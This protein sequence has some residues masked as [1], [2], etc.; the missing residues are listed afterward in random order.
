[1]LAEAEEAEREAEDL[2]AGSRAA[3]A[4]G[5][6][7]ESEALAQEAASLRMQ[8]MAVEQQAQESRLLASIRETE[9]KVKPLESLP[10]LLSV[11]LYHW[12]LEK[13]RC[14]KCPGRV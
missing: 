8:S 10:P 14:E 11:M 1:M 3:A 2:E 7:D 13:R 12:G 5:H 9:A 6:A 4:A